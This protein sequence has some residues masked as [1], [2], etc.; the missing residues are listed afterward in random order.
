[1]KPTIDWVRVK[2][3]SN[4]TGYSENAIRSKIKNG[5]WI[6]NVHFRKAPDGRILFSLEAITKWIEG[7]MA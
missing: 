4:L 6:K 3:L 1:M 7:K 5:V 2:L